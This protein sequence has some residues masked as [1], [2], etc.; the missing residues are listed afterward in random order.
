MPWWGI[1]LLLL[2]PFAI[3]VL[4]FRKLKRKP[5]SVPSTFLWK[6]SIE[7]FTSTACSNGCGNVLLLLQILAVLARSTA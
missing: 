2:L 6:K 1:L 5:L 3:L 4:Y 7:D